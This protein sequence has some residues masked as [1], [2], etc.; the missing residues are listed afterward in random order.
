M[1]C[2]HMALS[3]SVSM[4]FVL[5]GSRLAAAERTTISL[6]GTWRVTDGIAPDAIPANFDH[7]VAVPGLANQAKPSF[8]DVDNYM[9]KEVLDCN[10]PRYKLS[11]PPG[12]GD[13]LGWT[14]QKRNY[15]WYER[16][17]AVPA[18][19]LS[20]VLVIGKAQFGTAVWL[21]GKKIGEHIGCHT[22]G[23]FN[24]TDAMNWS[25]EN[26][27][28]VRI[29]AHPGAM[30]KGGFYGLDGEKRDWT[31][32]IYDSVSLEMAD[33]PVIETLQVA[34]QID[35]SEILVQTKLKN[36]GAARLAR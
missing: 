35:K 13:G 9:T 28:L 12:K 25:G 10:G 26:R 15:L 2:R 6:D 20:A 31:P 19:R 36:L 1:L 24:V 16:T 7:T 33:N 8:P 18:K 17:F 3:A 27:L 30:P 22:A 4:R 34:P 11:P 21:N 32:G 14:R 23:R 5:C 29:G